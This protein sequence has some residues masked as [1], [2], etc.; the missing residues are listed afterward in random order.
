MNK[1]IKMRGV[2]GVALVII[3]SYVL[4]L[5]GI[6]ICNRSYGDTHKGIFTD[7]FAHNVIQ[8]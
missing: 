5:G 4:I 1:D 6:S 8:E 7:E 2:V 3:I